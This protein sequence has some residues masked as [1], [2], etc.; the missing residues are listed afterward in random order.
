MPSR[1]PRASSMSAL[2]SAG[3]N[4]PSSVS[5]AMPIS[6]CGCKVR[7]RALPSNHAFNAGTALAAAQMARIRRAVMSCL[8]IHACRSASSTKVVGT[9]CA[10]ASAITRAIL[11]RTPLSCS[12]WPD[13]ATPGGWV[14]IGLPDCDSVLRCCS[15]LL[16]SGEGARRADE[17]AACDASVVCCVLSPPALPEGEGSRS[18]ASAAACFTSCI[19]TVPSGPVA[20]TRARSTPS[21]RAVARTAGTA[22][23]PPTASAASATTALPTCMAPTTVPASAGSALA[24]G[25]GAAGSGSACGAPP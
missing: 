5:T 13:A 15:S 1:M 12:G 24:V 3:T 10:W 21:L 8:P 19:V 4:R 23:T 11:R 6:T 9:T 18:D 25:A 7:V 14:R 2:R 22:F 16:P 17:G 20:R